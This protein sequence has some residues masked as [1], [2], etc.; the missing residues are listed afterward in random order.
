ME[1]N[2][3]ILGGD[4]MKKI[5]FGVAAYALAFLMT[6]SGGSTKGDGWKANDVTPH[7]TASSVIACIK[8]VITE[9]EG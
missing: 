7:T 2:Q 1:D 6:L 3:K 5:M 8:S 4:F 9:D